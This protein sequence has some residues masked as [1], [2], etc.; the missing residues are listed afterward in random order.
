MSAFSPFEYDYDG[1]STEHETECNKQRDEV[2]YVQLR[3]VRKLRQDSL[4]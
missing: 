4:G 1:D 2:E 3:M